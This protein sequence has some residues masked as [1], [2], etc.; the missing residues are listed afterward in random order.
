MP[1]GT[2][3]WIGT[4]WNA[5]TCCLQPTT[6]DDVAFTRAIVS[7][8]VEQQ[9]RLNLDPTRIWVAGFS[10]GAMMAEVKQ[11][12]SCCPCTAGCWP[13]LIAT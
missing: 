6:V 3:G 5:G 2:E 8:L 7:A 4:G 1:C 10:N 12:S 11:R 13:P 9:Q